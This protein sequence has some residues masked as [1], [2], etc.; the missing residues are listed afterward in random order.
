MRGMGCSMEEW[1]KIKDF[2]GHYSVSS[3]GRVR[4]EVAGKS[5]KIGRFLKHRVRPDGYNEVHLSFK[6]KS[7]LIYVQRLVAVCFMGIKDKGYEINHKDGNKS[8]NRLENLEYVTRKDNIIHAIRNGLRN[9]CSKLTK[10]EAL[11][12]RRLMLLGRYK[13]QEV[14][15]MFKTTQSNVSRIVNRKHWKH[16]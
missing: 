11:E 1:R 15:L 4:R 3:F 12:I 7:K 10:E 5:T 13:Q 2:N 16:L 8:N 14:A 6:K 9:N